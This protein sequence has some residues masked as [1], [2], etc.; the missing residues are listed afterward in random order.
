[1]I[2]PFGSRVKTNH[3]LYLALYHVQNYAGQSGST[4][5]R[6]VFFGFTF[7]VQ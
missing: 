1:M 6:L 2:Y 4:V 7:F 5:F 3:T